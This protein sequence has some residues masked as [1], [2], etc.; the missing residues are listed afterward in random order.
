MTLKLLSIA[1]SIT[2]LA[3]CGTVAMQTSSKLTRTITIDHSRIENKSIYVQV[4]NTANSGGEN[5]NLEE[6]IKAELIKKGYRI[7]SSSQGS[8]FGLFVNVLF[9]NN[10]TEANAVKAAAGL[11]G[12]S[13]VV[14][15]GSGSSTK[16]SLLIGAG[17]ALIGAVGSKAVADDT[18]KAVI[19]VNVKNYNSNTE[20]QTR[21]FAKAVQMNLNLKEALPILEKESTRSI[22][23]I[24]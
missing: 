24:F 20:S 14:A 16:D 9:A 3:G 13:G 10:L 18:F 7:S 6:S 17:A 15:M 22:V 11:G 19:D 21:V 5:M 1:S 8:G 2:I 4:T 23:N 12:A